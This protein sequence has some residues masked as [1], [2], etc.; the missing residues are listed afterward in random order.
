MI[1]GMCDVAVSALILSVI[2]R[3]KGA[4]T[5]FAVLG[6]ITN[7]SE[8]YTTFASGWTHDRWGTATMLF[9]ESGVSLI[10]IVAAAWFLRRSKLVNTNRQLQVNEAD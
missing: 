4:A 8:V 9:I 3:S 5:K 2:G 10:S 6:G 1:V 7:L